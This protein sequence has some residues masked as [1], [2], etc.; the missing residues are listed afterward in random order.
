MLLNV[1]DTDKKRVIEI[2][3]SKMNPETHVHLVTKEKFTTE[4][5]DSFGYSAPIAPIEVVEEVPTETPVVE[6][7][8]TPD[9]NAMT[10]AELYDYALT[11]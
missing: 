1:F 8:S 3:S 2:D 4:Q 10:K 9:Y 7:S 6:E 5:L 11:L